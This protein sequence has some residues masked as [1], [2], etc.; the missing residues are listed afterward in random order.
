MKYIKAFFLTIL[1]LLR[2]E[3]SAAQQDF[4]GDYSSYDQGSFDLKPNNTYTWSPTGIC[5]NRKTLRDSGTF[6]ITGDTL[7]TF[8]KMFTS[9]KKTFLVIKLKP[10]LYYM[11]LTKDSTSSNYNRVNFIKQSLYT[12]VNPGNFEKVPLINYVRKKKEPPVAGATITDT[13][14]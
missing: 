11:T 1:I 7:F 14:I 10:G 13:E 12:E 4:F 3:D 9:S 8:S 5:S 2:I 6:C